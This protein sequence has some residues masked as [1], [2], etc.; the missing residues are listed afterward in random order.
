MNK[1]PFHLGIIMDG[2]RRW[3][4][5]RG[6]PTLLGHRK[7]MENLKKMIESARNKGIKMLTVF[8]FSTENWQ[9]SKIEVSYLMKLFAKGLDDFKKDL[10]HLN[11][12]GIRFCVVGKREKFSVSLIK[13]MEALEAR[14]ENNCNMV[15]NLALNYGGRLEITE[16]VKKIMAQG[17]AAD[18]LAEKNIS[19][20]L[21]LPD[22]DL[23]IRT[24][25]E[26][27]LSNFLIWQA[28]YA[29]LYFSDKYWPEFSE[30][31]LDEALE[32]YAQRQRRG[33]K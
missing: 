17:V 11:D 25:R 30:K 4:K 24:G 9:R 2:N 19:E 31:D 26:K 22:L 3:A 6:L 20:N 13:K 15:F 29:E 23:L 32:D 16:A 33:G 8:A 1:I 27:R 18:D 14:T 12:R 10:P 21:W 28:A 7:G 5:E